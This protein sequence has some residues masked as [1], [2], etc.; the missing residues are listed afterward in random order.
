MDQDVDLTIAYMMNK[1]QIGL[2]GDTHGADIALVA[3]MAALS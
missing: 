2:V 1:M 3:A